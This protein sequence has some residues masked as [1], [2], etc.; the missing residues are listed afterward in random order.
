MPKR[1]ARR[2]PKQSKHEHWAKKSA[3]VAIIASIITFLGGLNLLIYSTGHITPFRSAVV[4][5]PFWI[6]IVT[7]FIIAILVDY[8]ANNLKKVCWIEDIVGS[9]FATLGYLAFFGALGILAFTTIPGFVLGALVL[10]MLFY[11][12]FQVGHT[13]DLG[14]KEAG[15]NV[16]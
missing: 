8:A 2:A 5:A 1:T 14:L 13:I 4:T 11:V 10:F 3:I 15:V 6:A 9:I 12:G 16:N 7:L